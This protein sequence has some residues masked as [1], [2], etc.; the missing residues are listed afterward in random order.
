MKI[1]IDPSS[2]GDPKGKAWPPG[3]DNRRGPNPRGFCGT[4]RKYG[5]SLAEL[6][7]KEVGYLIDYN[8]GK[9]EPQP[10]FS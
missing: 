5:G 9:A 10:A 6:L 3:V 7:M 8:S 1:F 4:L 2:C